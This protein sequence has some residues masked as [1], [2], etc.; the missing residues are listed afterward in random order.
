M[1]TRRKQIRGPTSL[2]LGC[3]H[4][5]RQYLEYEA[6]TSE[7]VFPLEEALAIQ[8]LDWQVLREL[9]HDLRI[10]HVRRWRIDAERHHE[11]RYSVP[12][13]GERGCFV[14]V[15]TLGHGRDARQAVAGRL[16]SSLATRN[17]ARPAGRCCTPRLGAPHKR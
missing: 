17:F 12:I 2:F 16:F 9:V 6:G 7:R 8:R 11:S 10:R 15:Q 13:F 5:P 14:R 1:S 3:V 4:E